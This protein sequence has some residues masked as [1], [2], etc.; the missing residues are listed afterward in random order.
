MADTM[1]PISI[2]AKWLEDED[3]GPPRTRI[4]RDEKYRPIAMAIAGTIEEHY[5]IC[6]LEPDIKMITN[7]LGGSFTL[8]EL[9]RIRQ[10]LSIALAAAPTYGDKE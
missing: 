5:R 4:E 7:A 1:D 6:H 8:D 3:V 2:I 10:I 9:E